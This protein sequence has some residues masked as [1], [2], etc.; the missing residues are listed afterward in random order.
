MI[1]QKQSPIH[2]T[3]Q[4]DGIWQLDYFGRPAGFIGRI[5]VKNRDRHHWRAVSVHGQV[6]HAYS[7]ES[8]RQWLLAAY[9]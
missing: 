9:H 6:H 8:A 2:L 7:L 5:K 3:K 1:Q 4:P